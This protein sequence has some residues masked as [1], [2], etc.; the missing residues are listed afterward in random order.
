MDEI[1]KYLFCFTIFFLMCI[2]FFV[3][4]IERIEAL[5]RLHNEYVCLECNSLVSK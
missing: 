1:L 3:P 4:T 2:M 5:E